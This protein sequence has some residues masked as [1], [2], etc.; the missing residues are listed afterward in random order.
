MARDVSK[1]IQ[2]CFRVG[3]KRLDCPCVVALSFVY[4][5]RP[6]SYSSIRAHVANR[7]LCFNVVLHSLRSLSLF[8]ASDNELYVHQ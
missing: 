8:A 5:I 1:R 3:V 6:Y 2:L 7:T 4:D